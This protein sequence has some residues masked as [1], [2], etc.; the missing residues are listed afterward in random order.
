MGPCPPLLQAQLVQARHKLLQLGMLR[1]SSWVGIVARVKRGVQLPLKH[2]K[3]N[4]LHVPSPDPE[5][6]AGS[7]HQDELRTTPD[8]AAQTK[9]ISAVWRGVKVAAD[10]LECRID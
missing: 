7:C 8:G 2:A 6:P 1:R 10:V 3:V 4:G 5:K 9:F